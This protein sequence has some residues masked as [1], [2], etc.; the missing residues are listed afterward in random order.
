[1]DTAL[2]TRFRK[3]VTA[4]PSPAVISALSADLK[5]SKAPPP[6]R[7]IDLAAAFAHAAF[8]SPQRTAEVYDAFASGWLGQAVEEPA[9][10]HDEPDPVAAP[11]AL[12]T[13]YFAVIDD[14]VAGILDAGAITARTAALA[15]HLPPEHL[16]RLIAMSAAWPGIDGAAS[17]DMPQKIE[18]ETL[19]AC[20]PGSLGAE[21]HALIVDNKFDLEVLD[22]EEIGLG[23][24]PHPLGW[25]NTRI[26]QTHDLWHITA[27]YETTALH[28]IAISAFQM[29]QFGHNYSAQFLS[30][31]A[32]VGAVTPARLY[33]VLMDTIATA[34]AHGR[35]TPAM[36]GIRW[37]E[38]WHQP[39]GVIRQRHGIETYDRPYRAD[40]IERGEALGAFVERVRGFAARILPW[41]DRAKAA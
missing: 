28:E 36:M 3:A 9:V 37:E 16:D 2:E 27:G 22:R 10:P 4:I 40:L 11:D 8:L 34:W 24:L 31:T 29:A 15:Q 26:L 14:A 25:L 7:R 6:E 18:L 12:W 33:P 13:D 32:G 23:T 19:A 5:A 41:M 38:E 1:M 35:E 21:F 30:M 39:A 20:P 17:E